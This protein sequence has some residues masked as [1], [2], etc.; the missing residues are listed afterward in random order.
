M[1]AAPWL[2]AD[3]NWLG[4]VVAERRPNHVV[5]SVRGDAGCRVVIT[6]P[7]VAIEVGILHA[8]LHSALL[9]GVELLPE[10]EGAFADVASV[11]SAGA[12]GAGR[13]GGGR[14][15]FDGASGVVGERVSGD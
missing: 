14:K 15:S 4:Q 7:G 10:T 3:R 12:S 13:A 9:S 8:P 11:A 2:I 6:G 5:N 1:G